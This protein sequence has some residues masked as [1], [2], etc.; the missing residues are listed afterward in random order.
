MPP[1][2]RPRVLKMSLADFI[3]SRGLPVRDTRIVSPMPWLSISPSPIA[4]FILPL[5]IEPAYVIPTWS[6]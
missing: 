2:L 1:F 3:S 5:I 4:D 6:G